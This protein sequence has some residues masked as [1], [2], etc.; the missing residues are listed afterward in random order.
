MK[1][2]A[3]C[4]AADTE[5]EPSAEVFASG[6]GRHQNYRGVA[7]ATNAAQ[8]L[9]ALERAGAKLARS[10]ST[11]PHLCEGVGWVL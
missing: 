2:D 7:V 11:I 9:E 1:V 4:I 6:A 8:Y 5:P 3:E 10:S